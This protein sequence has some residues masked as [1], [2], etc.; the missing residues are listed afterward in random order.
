M[1]IR[2]RYRSIPTCDSRSRTGGTKDGLVG[3]ELHG[4]TMG[5]VGTGAIGCRVAAI[6]SAFG[7]R[8][9]AYSRT[10][11]PEITALGAT[12]VSLEELMEQSDIVSLHCLLYTSRELP[13]RDQGRRGGDTQVRLHSALHHQT[14]LNLRCGALPGPQGDRAAGEAG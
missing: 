4:K 13:V 12:Y 14:L 10:E 8:L 9:L 11:R 6:A 5:I 1:C 7:C 2:D 3:P